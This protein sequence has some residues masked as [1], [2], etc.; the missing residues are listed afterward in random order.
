M[1]FFSAEN[2]AHTMVK[3]GRHDTLGELRA[4]TMIFLSYLEQDPP[5]AC[6]NTQLAR[7]AWILD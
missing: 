2:A 7:A 1:Q 3:R 6:G 5:R 4:E